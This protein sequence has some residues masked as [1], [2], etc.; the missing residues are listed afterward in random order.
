MRSNAGGDGKPELCRRDRGPAGEQH[1]HTDGNQKR[2]QSRSP[3]GCD[4]TMPVL[5]TWLNT[6]VDRNSRKIGP[7]LFAVRSRRRSLRF[8]REVAQDLILV[9]LS[10]SIHA[11]P[12]TFEW[13]EMRRDPSSSLNLRA[14]SADIR[15]PLHTREVAGSNPAA[16]I[17]GGPSGVFEPPLTC[18]ARAGR[19]LWLVPAFRAYQGRARV[20]SDARRARKAR[21]TRLAVAL[22]NSTVMVDFAACPAEAQVGHPPRETDSAGA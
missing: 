12:P 8:D 5:H 7:L 6:C 18:A 1:H 21:V 11:H 20:G 10:A 2:T 17:F 4:C 9:P 16:P 14:F 13:A 3:T 22:L 15:S 19:R